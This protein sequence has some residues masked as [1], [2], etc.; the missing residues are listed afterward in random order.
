MRRARFYILILGLTLLPQLLAA[1]DLVRWLADAGQLALA[2][3]VP[4]LLIILNLPMIGEVLR[5]KQ[6]ARLPRALVALFAQPWTAWW[7]GSFFYALLRAGWTVA[8]LGPAPMP[9]WLALLP[10]AL[11][12]Y[13]TSFGAHAL[14]RERVTVPVAGL[15]PRRG[16][17]RPVALSPPPSGPHVSKP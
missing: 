8:H 2:L 15:P 12:L 4:G 17:G 14:R 1:S 9:V 11:A 6:K 13:G 10:Y 3:S 5:R 16:G 7:L